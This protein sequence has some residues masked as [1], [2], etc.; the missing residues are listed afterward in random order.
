MTDSESMIEPVS[1][2]ILRSSPTVEK[3]RLLGK[4]RGTKVGTIFSSTVSL[5]QIDLLLFRTFW[6][7]Y[8]FNF[9]DVFRCLEFFVILRLIVVGVVKVIAV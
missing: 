6:W 3:K 9:F 2:S 4:V 8:V 5:N 7:A 1:V